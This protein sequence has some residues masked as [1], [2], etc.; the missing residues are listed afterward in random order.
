MRRGL[1]AASYRPVGNRFAREPAEDFQPVEIEPPAAIMLRDICKPPI[2]SLPASEQSQIAQA[3]VAV[4]AD[5][6][7]VV[8]GE[9]ERGGGLFDV[10]RDGDI[11]L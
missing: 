4:L 9:A 11:G 2:H 8:K 6:D 10:L 7:V 5:D 1:P 3:R